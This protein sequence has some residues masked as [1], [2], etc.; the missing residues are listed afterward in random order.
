M[1][2]KAACAETFNRDSSAQSFCCCAGGGKT[3][4]VHALLGGSDWQAV[5]PINGATKGVQVVK[6][7][8]GLW[9]LLGW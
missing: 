4:L 5:D 1:L 7:R 2:A 8:K 6:V 3:Q 9:L